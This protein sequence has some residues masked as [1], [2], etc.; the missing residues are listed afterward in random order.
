M[1][2]GAKVG[3]IFDS[4]KCKPKDFVRLPDI[5][6]VKGFEPSTPC[7]QSRCANRT[8]LRPESDAKLIKNFQLCKL[9]YGFSYNN[10]LPH[11]RPYGSM[12]P[13]LWTIPLRFHGPMAFGLWTI[14]SDS[15]VLWPLVYGLSPPILWSYG[16]W[17]M[18]YPLRFH[19]TMAFGLWT[20]PSDSMVLWPP[21]LWPRLYGSMVLNFVTGIC[22]FT[23]FS[24][25]LQSP[26][27]FVGGYHPRDDHLTDRSTYDH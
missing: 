15:M 1:F 11:P 9:G 12:V 7:S 20:T 24:L 6:G 13:S 2:S 4:C 10:Y 22:T 27:R 19:G 23:I 25:T 8:A 5:V 17:S 21:V 18:D 3:K 26:P 14:P 16:L